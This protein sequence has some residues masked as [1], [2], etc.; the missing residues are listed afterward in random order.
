M[1]YNVHVVLKIC[2]LLYKIFFKNQFLVM[3]CIVIIFKDKTLNLQG[4]NTLSKNHIY[5]K[6]INKKMS[7]TWTIVSIYYNNLQENCSKIHLHMKKLFL[8]KR[9]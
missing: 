4:I 3:I 5:P 8:G 6:F 1:G 2:N 9:S 7:C